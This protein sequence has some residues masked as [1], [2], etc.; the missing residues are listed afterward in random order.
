MLCPAIPLDD[1]HVGEVD[2]TDCCKG[3]ADSAL[4]W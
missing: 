2:C 3:S 4:W 1:K